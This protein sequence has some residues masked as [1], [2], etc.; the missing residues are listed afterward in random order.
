MKDWTPDERKLLGLL[1]PPT[2]QQR[3]AALAA[4]HESTESCACGHSWYGHYKIAIVPPVT[5]CKVCDCQKFVA[6]L[7]DSP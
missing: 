5:S 2:R 1:P 4:T 6:V 7:E 3:N